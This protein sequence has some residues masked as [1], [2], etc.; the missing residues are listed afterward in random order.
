MDLAM[1]A[2]K[3]IYWAAA[4]ELV[5]ELRVYLETCAEIESLEFAGSFRRGKETIGNLDVLIVS[6]SPSVVMDR[7]AAF[8]RVEKTLERMDDRISLRIDPGFSIDIRF[9]SRE[10]L[11][12]ALQHFTGSQE[13]NRQ[14]GQIAAGFQL[15]TTPA[16]VFRLVDDREVLVGG[17]AEEDVYRA[18]NLPW[19]PPELREGRHEFEWAAS[20]SMP[21]LLELAD[22]KG[23]LHMHTTASD[24]TASLRDMVA[25]AKQRGLQYI[26]ITD[27]S[28][29]VS[30]ARGLD[31][32]RLREQWAQIDQIN[33]ELTDV[34]IF[35]GIECDIL[36]NGQMDLEDEVLAEADWVLASVHYGQDQPAAQITRR[37]LNAI[38]NPHVDVIAHPT[39]RLLNRR[40]AYDVQ[41]DDVFAAAAAQKKRLELNANPARLD[42]HDEHCARARDLG[43]PVVIN[44]DAHSPDGLDVMRFG[45]MQARRGG[46]TKA[47]VFNTL[48]LASMKK[49]LRGGI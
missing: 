48:D 14:L 19:I 12:S 4:H 16:G 24:G 26:A 32:N 38:E 27:H 44:S 21:Q 1:S 36:E 37:I 13:H 31:A 10:C 41:M 49:A 6:S 2:G 28:K 29:R 42:L 33:Q 35:K 30:L 18:V 3:R 39:G 23:D 47:Q 17:K 22:I 9:V 34:F 25:A 43:I 46:L 40:K 8:E 20:N 45:V 15:K 5:S 7:C 11:G